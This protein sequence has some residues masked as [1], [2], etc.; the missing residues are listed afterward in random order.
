MCLTCT[1]PT[2]P[3]GISVSGSPTGGP[4]CSGNSVSLSVV[5]GS[6]GSGAGAKWVWYPDSSLSGSVGTGSPI[7]QSPKETTTYYVRAEGPCGP[8]TPVSAP[9][10]IRPLPQLASQP[11]NYITAC[12][13]SGWISFNCPTTSGTAVK[14]VQWNASFDGSYTNAIDWTGPDGAHK[15]FT[16]QTTQTLMVA[17][18]D[19]TYV[20]CTITDTCDLTVK[21]NIAKLTVQRTDPDTGICQ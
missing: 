10:S 14:S 2:A 18:Q 12:D 16:G 9:V 8:S 4:Y 17:T 6:L 19:T 7:N 5:N 20:W 21:S 11:Q 3:T 15:Y 13:E 1:A